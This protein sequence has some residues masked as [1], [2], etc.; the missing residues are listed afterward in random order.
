MVKK[1]ENIVSEY[2]NYHNQYTKM[3]GNRTIVLMQVGSFHEA[4]CIED[5]GPKLHVIHAVLE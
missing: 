3:F 2:I 1:N 5:K 4:Y